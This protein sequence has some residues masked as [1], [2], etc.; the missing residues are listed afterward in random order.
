MQSEAVDTPRGAAE[1][2]SSSSSSKTPGGRSA[3]RLTRLTTPASAAASDSA[4]SHLE[5]PAG[6]LGGGNNVKV[7]CRLRPMNEREKKGG[8]VPAATAS[9]ERKEVAVVRML[10]GGTGGGTRQVRSLFHFDEVLTSFSTQSEV[11]SATL[12]PLV[13]EVLSGYEATAFAYGQTGTGKTYTMEGDLESDGSRGLVPRTAAAVIERLQNG[14]YAEYAVTCSY[15]EIYNEELSDLLIP[16][17]QP[18]PRLD[19]KDGGSGKGV[20]CTGL[21]EV[22]VSS[23]SDILE[24]VRRAQERRRVAETRVNARSSRSHCIFTM[25]VR[26]RR[27]IASGELENA[28]KLHLVDLAGSECAKKASYEEV[29]YPRG[30]QA[31]NEE[32]RERR[33]INQS[34]LTLGRV[35]SAL[36]DGTGRVP[37]RD[38][39]LTRLLQDALG[40]KCKTVVIATISPALNAVEETISTLTYA[41]QASGIKNRPV[42]SSLLRT[43]RLAAT[44]EGRNVVG[45]EATGGDWAELE[46]KVSYLT[47]EV[48]EAQAALARKY[49]EAQDHYERAMCA[50]EQLTEVASRL[51]SARFEAKQKAFA[52]GRL[53]EFADDRGEAVTKLLSALD[54]SAAHGAELRQ[55]LEESRTAAE[56]VRQQARGLCSESEARQGPLLAAARASADGAREAVADTHAAHRAATGVAAEITQEQQ[57]VLDALAAAA[58]KG[59][60]ELESSFQ[61]LFSEVS[62]SS[63]AAQART[64]EQQVAALAAIEAASAATAN[65]G[66]KV[67]V[68]AD[69][70]IAAADRAA[71][72]LCT[73]LM[74]GREVLDAGAVEAAASLEAARLAARQAHEDTMTRLCTGVQEPG[75]ALLT[76]LQSTRRGVASH[77]E[78]LDSLKA[79]EASAAK[80][81]AARWQ[82]MLENLNVSTEAHAVFSKKGQAALMSELTGLTEELDRHGE[83]AATSLMVTQE[84]CQEASA[85]LAEA[86]SRGRTDVGNAVNEAETC[87]SSTWS[88]DRACL[89]R[90]DETLRRA[91]ADLSEANASER[92]QGCATS[93]AGA[94]VTSLSCAVA[95]LAETRESIAREVAQLQEQRAAE[96]EIVTGLQEQRDALRTDTANFRAALEAVNSDLAKGREQLD[97]LR[98]AQERARARVVDAVTAVMKKELDT[99]GVDL[100]EGFAT[101][102]SKIRECEVLTDR[103]SAS[104][105]SAEERSAEAVAKASSAAKSWSEGVADVRASIN[106]A[107]ERAQEGAQAVEAAARAGEQQFA[108]MKAM[109]LEWGERSDQVGQLLEAAS[110]QRGELQSSLEATEP[111]WQAAAASTLQAADAWVEAGRQTGEVLHAGAV[112]RDEAAN[113][114]CQLR[115]TVT[116][117]REAAAE[118]VGAWDRDAAQ[119]GVALGELS[120]L[121]ASFAKEEE[122]EAERRGKVV[123]DLLGVA[124]SLGQELDL[125][126]AGTNSILGSLSA[127]LEEMPAELASRDSTLEVAGMAI[128]HCCSQVSETAASVMEGIKA[129]QAEEEQAWASARASAKEGVS[130]TTAAA[131]AGKNALNELQTIV[132]ASSIEACR[133]WQQASDLQLATLSEVGKAVDVAKEASAAATSAASGRILVELDK[134]SEA[135]TRAVA[136]VDALLAGAEKALADQHSAVREGLEAMPLA[137][138]SHPGEVPVPGCP[139]AALRPQNVESVPRPSDEELLAEFR[140]ECCDNEEEEEKLSIVSQAS[141]R[142]SS[143]GGLTVKPSHFEEDLKNTTPSKERTSGGKPSTKDL[144]SSTPPGKLRLEATQDAGPVAVIKTPAAKAA[145]S[146]AREGSGLKL[147]VA[148]L[149]SLK[150]GAAR[151]AAAAS[152][153]AGSL[154][155][156][157]DVGPAPR[158]VLSDLTSVATPQRRT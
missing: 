67:T 98:V 7:V 149:S 52:A 36:R 155:D 38:S 104:A 76:A 122:G 13:D 146:L 80:E 1:D 108:T 109:S 121:G 100:S 10:G 143:S 59:R 43:I 83:A 84:K 92:L 11:F 22:S 129:F 68:A 26:C 42:A 37:Y 139:E 145:E 158:A 127:Q 86:S 8:T 119:H 46:M 148:G 130:G 54:A 94:L 152:G 95:A 6:A 151:A 55:R 3:S 30:Q 4:G 125:H 103:A 18:H 45:A 79:D 56:A 20:F 15:L 71:A 12:D 111:K 115:A 138:F 141:S 102:S 27:S 17:Q 34:L 62:K 35:I 49:R 72:A 90:L 128:G 69:A 126:A 58:Q 87:L 57:K 118:V 77:A 66:E 78:G 9:T 150:A 21:S 144:E 137:A 51:S 140:A 29:S 75:Q 81:M 48:E 93:G 88:R 91:A 41:E 147:P 63:K 105:A 135:K 116:A 89:Q 112:A 14:G 28:G 101:T 96:Q 114:L 107:Q 44:G 131:E 39:K 133:Q 16:Q 47:Q 124:R 123:E 19:L 136:T 31:G 40:G 99:L 60:Q 153:K 120:E 25:K 23:V 73:R 50:E 154:R 142:G 32:E 33:S 156:R 2:R 65:A 157:D 97:H 74:G 61:Q 132:D 85:A 110:S 64:L 5:S 113:S 70:Q 24:L 53:A 134:G 106:A 82:K 117:R